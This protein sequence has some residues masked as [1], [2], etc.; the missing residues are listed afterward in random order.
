M[1]IRYLSD[2]HYEMG[3][4]CEPKPAPDYDVCVIAGDW[5]TGEYAIEGFVGARELRRHTIYFPGNHEFYGRFHA[6]ET[7]ERKM[8]DL[9]WRNPFLHFLNPGSVVI[10]G[11]RFVAATLWTDYCL[12]GAEKQAAAMKLAAEWMQDHRQIHTKEADGHIVRFMPRHALA[13]HQ[14]ELAFIEKTLATP[15]DGPT[16]VC[17]HHGPSFRSVPEEYDEDLLSA[18]F[19]SRLDAVIERHQPALWIHGH[20][21]DSMDYMIGDTRVVCNPAGYQHSPNLA[22]RWDCVIEIPTHDCEPTKGFGL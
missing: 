21:H 1:K 10:D 13:R 15:F 17:S 14:R 20:T 2:L 9:A 19:S 7:E 22:F 11:V 4:L 3:N 8:D 6:M 18:A 16:V 5:N 12:F